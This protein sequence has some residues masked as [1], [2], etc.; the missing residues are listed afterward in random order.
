MSSR[1]RVSPA[2]RTTVNAK[3]SRASRLRAAGCESGDSFTPDRFRKRSQAASA[4]PRVRYNPKSAEPDP[5]SEATRDEAASGVPEAARRRLISAREGCWGKTTRSK[6]FWIQLLIPV[7]TSA[8]SCG[9]ARSSP[10]VVT[11]ED[12]GGACSL[13]VPRGF[14]PQRRWHRRG[15]TH[16]VYRHLP[17]AVK[18]SAAHSASQSRKACGVETPTSGVATTHH[19]GS[20]SGSG[21]TSC[22]RSSPRTVPPIRNRGT[23]D[24][25]WAA[26]SNRRASQG[27]IS[28]GSL[29]DSPVSEESDHREMSGCPIH[30][31]PFA[32]WV[33]Y[34]NLPQPRPTPLPTP[35]TPPPHWPTRP[36]AR[37]APAA[38]FRYESRP[39]PSAP[40]S[41]APAPPSS[42]PCS[43]HRSARARRSKSAAEPSPPPA[44]PTPSPRRA[45]RASGKPWSAHENHQPAAHQCRD[46]G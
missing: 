31:A 8:D 16:L 27:G 35:P 20:I 26:I 36:P 41:P 22:P 38:A 39:R 33:G 13:P 44:A 15:S 32:R 14:L 24:P 6:S 37:P 19:A 1:S 30:R 2:E 3:A 21:Y 29:D 17:P 43:A 25:T 9:P 12:T 11:G 46:Q 40:A 4:S 10:I 34:R 18:P 23:S 45:T 28:A 7:R 5:D 42:T